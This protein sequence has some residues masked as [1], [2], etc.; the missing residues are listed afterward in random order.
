MQDQIIQALRR[1]AADE[2]VALARDWIARDGATAL[3][4]RWLALALQQQGQY[5]EALAELRQAIAQAPEDAE[6]HLQ[7]AGLLLAVRETGAAEAALS[8]ST[9][10]DPNQFDAYVMQAHLAIGRGDIDEAERIGRLA[11]RV[12]ADH[13]QIAAID[14]VIALRRGDA[15][16][17]LA[18]LSQAAEAMP[19]NTQVLFALALAY[20]QKGHLAFAE[21]ALSRVIVLQPPGTAL[22]AFMAQLAAQQGRMDDALE[23]IKGALAQVDGDTPALHR[24]AGELQ[25]QAGQPAEAVT[26]LRHALDHGPVDRR[27]LQA[28]LLAWQQLGTADEARDV[29]DAALARQPRAH[30]LWLTRLALAP[31]GGDEALEVAERWV[32]AMPEFLPALETLMRI[33]DMQGH[34]D[35]AEMVARQIVAIEPGRISGEQR[36]VEALLA[37]DPP[38]AIACVQAL[39]DGLPEHERTVLRPWL[40]LVQ[41]RAGDHAAAL[42]TWLAFHA[43]QAQHR[44]PLPPHAPVQPTRWPALG[45][46]AEDNRARPLLLWGA[47][48]SHVERVAMAMGAASAVLRRDRYTPTVPDDAL[49]SYLTVPGLASGKVRPAQVVESWKAALPGRGIQDGNVID[50]LL[51]WDNSVLQALRPHLPEGR[52]A[53]VLRDPRDMLLDWLAYG[54]PVP[55]AVRSAGEAARWLAESLSQVATLHEQDLY[56]HKLLRLDGR[57]DNAEAVSQLLSD[58]FGAPFPVLPSL[59]APRLPGGR[60][61]DYRGL[62]AEELALLTPVAVRLGYAAE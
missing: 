38:A 15:D 2:A 14:G 17:A 31:I 34:A 11:A 41:D 24:L 32:E 39:M 9:A 25:L 51:W 43:E 28:L 6:L 54:A 62:L 44:L 5:D 29:I 36:I 49:Q 18:L 37:R 48:G 13:P 19:D 58:A 8:R 27:V 60:W 47:P 1:N 26:H 20:L 16:R 30:E 42:S 35:E 12:Q 33:H 10:L 45:S 4:Q 23:A 56:P 52:L 61:R 3:T 53:I 46:V 40:A 22:R 21:R 57:E 7:Q 50:W 59:G 55:L